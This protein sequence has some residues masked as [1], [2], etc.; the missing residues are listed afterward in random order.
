[1]KSP[2][3]IIVSD[4]SDCLLIMDV[5]PWDVYPT[6]T[7]GAEQVVAE[8]AGRLRGRRLEYIDSEGRQDQL[9]V[10]DGKFAGF[11]PREIATHTTV[12]REE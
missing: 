6:V 5:G 2:H 1:M 12:H 11:A 3:Y 9:L 7:S 8:L 4:D 10:R